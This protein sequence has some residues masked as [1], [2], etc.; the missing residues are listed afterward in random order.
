M[1]APPDDTT[2]S[3][4][5]EPPPRAVWGTR[6]PD[7]AWCPPE[8][9]SFLPDVDVRD[10]IDAPEVA[11]RSLRQGP[12]ALIAASRRGRLHAH[13]GDHREDAIA[14]HEHATGWCGAVADGAGS[15]PWSRLGAAIA[16]QTFCAAFVAA[17]GPLGPRATAAARVSHD[18][19]RQFA[20]QSDIPLR[21]LRTTLLAAAVDGNQL[22]TLQVGD[23]GIVVVG[24]DNTVTLPQAGD[25]GEFS[26]EVHHFL[27]DDG[28]LERLVA[29][30]QIM[31]L[32][33]VRA[34]LLVSDGIEDPWYPLARHAPLLVESLEHG[35]T[36]ERAAAIA[37]A[38]GVQHAWRG[39]VAT[40]PDPAAA[41][42]EWMTF[43]KRGENDDRSVLFA[44]CLP[45]E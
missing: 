23:G 9:A 32:A 37:V 1:T 11:H 43:E 21:A 42:G 30:M 31:S 20:Q 12:W 13:R 39:T 33:S 45:P 26:G 40:A 5:D 14:M 36:D 27:P 29:S 7:V 6:I 10:A 25:A 24:R 15:A 28:S 19:L 16:T 35:L 18:A 17:T 38:N 34:V 4:I 22:A 3:L 44:R 8:W 2:P 41:L